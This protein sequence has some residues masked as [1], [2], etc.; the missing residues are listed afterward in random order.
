M[1]KKYYKPST[2]RQNVPWAK[3]GI[4]LALGTVLGL[5]LGYMGMGTLHAIFE[6]RGVKH[7]DH[8]QPTEAA[9][10]SGTR[11]RQAL[12]IDSSRQTSRK[13]GCV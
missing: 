6:T 10:E 9:A 12:Q 2:F 7:Y 13:E 4:Y 3:V 11:K 5:L 8:T 1:G